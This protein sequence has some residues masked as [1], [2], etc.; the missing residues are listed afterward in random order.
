MNKENLNFRKHFQIKFNFKNKGIYNEN[1]TNYLY[2]Q[3]ISLLH[4]K[5]I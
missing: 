4:S 5:N 3:L 2:I 1:H